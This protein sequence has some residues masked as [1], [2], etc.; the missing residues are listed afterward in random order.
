MKPLIHQ[1]NNKEYVESLTRENMAAYYSE[2]GVLW[3]S[4]LFCRNW[5]E[6]ENYQ[7]TVNGSAVGALRLSKDDVAYYIRDLQ[8]EPGW[9]RQGL[10]S[11]AIFFA[12]EVAR[13][14]GFRLLRLRVFS[15]NPAVTLYESI[16]F[17]ICRTEQGTH[18]MEYELS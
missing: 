9:Q 4:A 1:A 2:L 7:I 3:D 13:K 15:I 18:Y 8:I 17:R 11:N 14:A 16:G 6:F 5:N 10:G 12:M